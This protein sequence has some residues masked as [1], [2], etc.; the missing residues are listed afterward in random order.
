MEKPMMLKI[1][2]NSENETIALAEKLSKVFVKG[3]II[4]LTGDLGAGKTHFVK[5]LALGLGAKEVVTSPTFTIMNIYESGKMPIYHFDMYRLS[6]FEEAEALGFSEYFDS[7]TLDGI[8]I[9]EWPQNVEG[10]I[11]CNHLHID[12]IKGEKTNERIIHIRRAL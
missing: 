5:G 1:V 10:L 9:V 4:T 3:T 11:N 12:I 6:S 8:S 2:T 7:K